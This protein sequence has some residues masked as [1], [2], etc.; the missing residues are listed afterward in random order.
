MTDIWMG[1]DGYYRV[2]ADDI[3]SAAKVLRAHL[4]K[5]KEIGKWSPV[6]VEHEEFTVGGRNIYREARAIN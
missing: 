1:R 3:D 5:R 2:I 6:S 4:V